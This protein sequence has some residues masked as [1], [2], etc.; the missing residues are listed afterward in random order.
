[1]A[2]LEMKRFVAKPC[3]STTL[4]MSETARLAPA[5][6]RAARFDESNEARWIVQEVRK[7]QKFGF[8][9]GQFINQND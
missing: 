9:G 3:V 7:E 1:M 2:F 4:E 8:V 6:A 5:Q